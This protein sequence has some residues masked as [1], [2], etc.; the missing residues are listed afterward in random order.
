MA[1]SIYLLGW[2]RITTPN[3][4][5][6]KSYRFKKR[7]FIITVLSILAAVYYFARHN[8]YCEP[9]SKV[10]DFLPRIWCNVLLFRSSNH[11]HRIKSLYGLGGK[12]KEILY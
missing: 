11:F 8:K 6:A 3:A 7:L 12:T 1:L 10:S 5:E 2:H 9:L 4:A